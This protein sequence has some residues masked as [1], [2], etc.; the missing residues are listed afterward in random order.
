EKERI[1]RNRQR[2]KNK[3]IKP[4]KRITIPEIKEESRVKETAQPE[5]TPTKRKRRKIRKSPKTKISS[6]T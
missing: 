1:T 2:E 5:K 3:K 4:R 6:T